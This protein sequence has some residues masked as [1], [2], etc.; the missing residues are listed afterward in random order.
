MPALLSVQETEVDVDRV[1]VLV[2]ADWERLLHLVE[3]ESRVP[4]RACGA[5][6][7][8]A[9]SRRDP[10]FGYGA[11]DLGF[12]PSG[13]YAGHGVVTADA[14]RIGRQLCSFYLA[15]TL[16]DD[17]VVRELCAIGEGL[18]GRH[19][20]VELCHCVIGQDSVEPT[21]GR[22]FGPVHETYNVQRRTGD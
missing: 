10:Q 1:A 3:E 16:D 2:Q 11:K 6:D 15:R 21:G 20:F 14:G 12:Y 7:G 17:P 13:G 18:S 5:H 19:Q 4:M 9:G 8:S 22:R